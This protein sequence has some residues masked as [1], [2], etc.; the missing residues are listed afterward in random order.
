MKNYNLPDVLGQ[1]TLNIKALNFPIKA[2][3]RAFPHVRAGGSLNHGV[4]H[5]EAKGRAKVLPFVSQAFTGVNEK[6]PLFSFSFL[7]YYIHH[8]ALAGDRKAL[9]EALYEYLRLRGVQC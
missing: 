8:K 9:R 6:E 7:E 3:S 1:Y 2:P 5:G 4:S